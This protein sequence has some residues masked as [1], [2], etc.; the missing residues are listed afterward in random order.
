MF[1]RLSLRLRVFLFFLF[2]ALGSAGLIGAALW[3]G[4][5]RV[6]A[7]SDPQPF[8]LSGVAAVFAVGGLITWV[9][10]LFDENMARPMQALAAQLRVGA[11]TGEEARLDAG[12]ARYLG[13]LAPAASAVARELS[14]TRSALAEAVARETTRLA[15]E[16][17]RLEALLADVSI[18]V[19]LCSADHKIVFYNGFVRTLLDGE[20]HA[21]LDRSVLDCLREGPVRLA[22]AR[23]AGGQGAGDQTSFT[24]AT[25]SGGRMFDA[26]M[27]LVP[28]GNDRSGGYVLSLRDVTADLGL[29][30]EREALLAEMIDRIRRR[31]ANLDTMLSVHGDSG[32]GEDGDPIAA[33]LVGESR[34]LVDTITR[35][36]RR[37]EDGMGRWW[38]RAAISDADLFDS[39]RARLKAGRI[40]ITARPC[41]L[42][43][44]CDGFLVVALLARLAE[45]LKAGGAEGLSVAAEP[46]TSGV[47]LT[48][49]WR[50]QALSEGVLEDWI[51]EPVEIGEATVT[52]RFVLDRHGTEIWPESMGD[53]T[54]RLCLPLAVA[55]LDAAEADRMQ[56]AAVYD[57]SLFGRAPAGDLAAAPIRDLTF[58]VFD[59]ETT[60]LLPSNG[61]EI[62]QIAGMRVLN[63]RLL[64]AE[65]FDTLVDPGRPIPAASTQIH[66]ITA[67]M[68]AGAPKIAEAGARFRDF[69]RDAVLVAHNAPFDLA[70]FHKHAAVIGAEFD[71]PVLDT[72]LLSAVLFGTTEE[73]TLDALCARLGVTIP[74]KDRHTALGDT[75]ATG[76]AFVAMIA[77]LEAQ[78]LATFGA[79]HEAMKS[80]SRLYKRR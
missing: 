49:G 45:R 36:A 79:V 64:E 80:Q 56:R 65:T 31:A 30:L 5:S 57:F 2:L 78:G 68:V 28:I 54:Q 33:A 70:F 72:V 6:P 7:P 38:P 37:Y 73:H 58:V 60:G 76:K 22:Y 47:L 12:K 55:P 52:G 24:C 69:C 53:G 17:E 9:W 46:D 61:D 25:V 63:G 42:G 23:L 40:D 39:L 75:L 48:L 43:V 32:G 20:A 67:P 14:G 18:G 26:T 15:E 11:H 1:T 74:E 35:L 71:N 59:T 21:Q 3:F 13:D 34:D 66:G 10:R 8:V 4:Y 29:H 27:R 44:R 77:L 51:G 19:L 50:G 41:G 16:K 62:V